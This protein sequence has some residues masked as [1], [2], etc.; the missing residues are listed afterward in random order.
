M[1]Y[2]WQEIQFQSLY[3]KK[4]KNH[5]LTLP[6]PN[7]EFSLFMRQRFSAKHNIFTGFHI[8]TAI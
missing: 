4:K 3:L 6:L 7:K 5:G 1:E 8:F 2:I